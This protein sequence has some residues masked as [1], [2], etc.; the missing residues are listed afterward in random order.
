MKSRASLQLME[1]LIMILVFALA[2]ALCLQ[3]F[4]KAAEISRQ[5]ACQDAAVLV[6]RNAVETYKAGMNPHDTPHD[7]HFVLEI[8]ENNEDISG[9]EGVEIAVSC[10]CGVQFC[11][12]AGRQ[13]VSP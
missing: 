2:A 4:G 8:T 3:V 12:T 5:T 11:L 13:G 1:Q 7:P 9:F 10:E 6:A